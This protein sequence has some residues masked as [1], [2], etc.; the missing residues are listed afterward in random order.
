MT[1]FHDR[2][3]RD[4]M[5]QFCTGVVIVTGSNNGNL[6]G[7]AA[8]SFVSLSLTPPLVVVCPGKTSTSWPKIRDTGHFCI[9]VLAEDQQHISDVFALAG[10]V[11]DIDWR[12]GDSGAPILDG[13]L[14]YVD[15]V[16]ESE[17][18]GG[19]HTIAVG[20]VIDL[21]ILDRDRGPLLFFRG[22]Y[23]GFRS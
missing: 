13:V 17:H 7:F 21:D 15:C 8:Q 6:V 3:F 1:K 9:N 18:D 2:E 16:L 19:D 23:G 11:A 5:G 22:G 10:K 4:T 12:V 20:R 14:V